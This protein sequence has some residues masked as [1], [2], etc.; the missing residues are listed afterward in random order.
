MNEL[1]KIEKQQ[2]LIEKQKELLDKKLNELKKIDYAAKTVPEVQKNIVGGGD[3]IKELA[4]FKIEPIII[5]VVAMIGIILVGLDKIGLVVGISATA[6]IAMAGV[7]IGLWFI[8]FFLYLPRGKKVL[9]LKAFKNSGLLITAEKVPS[10]NTIH[11]SR[12]DEIPPVQVTRVNKHF[13]MMSGRPIIAC[14]EGVPKNVSLI[15]QYQ[16]DKSAKE[17]DNVIRTTYQTGWLDGVNT[18]QKFGKKLTDPQFIISILLL[19]LMAGMVFL[20]WGT[21]T[22]LQEMGAAINTVVQNTE[23][24]S[25]KLVELG[26]V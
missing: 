10:N 14:I 8:K 11:I 16:P 12:D 20:L 19:I 23:A 26:T 13:E 6:F 21:M 2:E 1:E 17:Y 3:L 5:L 22:Q 18:V 7:T 15:D 24:I 4:F 25:T 9:V